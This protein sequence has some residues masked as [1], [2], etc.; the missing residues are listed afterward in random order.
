MSEPPEYA[1]R[2]VEDEALSLLREAVAAW[3]SGTRLMVWHNDQR[4][5]GARLFLALEWYE[6]SRALVE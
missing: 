1:G 3:R 6:R 2:A 5:D 4:V